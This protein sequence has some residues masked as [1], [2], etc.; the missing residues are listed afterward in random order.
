MCFAGFWVL[1]Y[2]RLELRPGLEIC[3]LGGDS[4]R[5]SGLVRMA[6]QGFSVE[7]RG[8]PPSSAPQI[9]PAV[10]LCSI[11]K[12]KLGKPYS[13]C[14][15]PLLPFF[16]HLLFCWHLFANLPD[17]PRTIFSLEHVWPECTALCWADLEF[18]LAVSAA[19]HVL[20]AG[21]NED[22][23]SFN[24][25][26]GPRSSGIIYKTWQVRAIKLAKKDCRVETLSS[27]ALRT[28]YTYTQKP[29]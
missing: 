24:Y 3:V 12:C 25:W 9:C 6:S 11:I 19:R 8:W 7:L 16:S 26:F 13:S 27:G 29:L 1:P 22:H 20:R 5:R 23:L 15:F 4:G 17:T 21:I 28:I 10:T 18:Q 2:L 14:W